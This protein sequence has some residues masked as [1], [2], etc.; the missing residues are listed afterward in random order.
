MITALI[1]AVLVLREPQ[2][3]RIAALGLGLSLL[4]FAALWLAMGAALYDTSLFAW[5]PLDWL[6]DLVGGLAA[7]VLS[8]LLFPAVVTLILGLFLDRVAA[9]VE[10]LDYPALA[11]PRRQP[12]GEIIAVTL[13]LTAVTTLLN[14]IALPLYVLVP[15]INLILFLALNGYLFGRG[16]FEVVALR[17][18]DAA[19]AKSLRRRFA[20]PVFVAGVAVAG[21]FALPLVNL[22]APVI[23]IAFMVHVFEALPGIAPLPAAR[24]AV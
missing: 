5:R 14:I 23:A 22:V 8:W 19:A 10:G 2:L 16:Y 1:R 12:W 24:S 9:A 4:V 7:L 17:R 11:P 13:R 3:R 15:G 18:L 21:L 20:G 6:V